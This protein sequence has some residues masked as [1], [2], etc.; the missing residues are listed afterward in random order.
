M[1]RTKYLEDKESI[2][3]TENTED[4]VRKVY[5]ELVY[6]VDSSFSVELDAIPVDCEGEKEFIEEV[7]GGTYDHE[8]FIELEEEEVD[9]DPYSVDLEHDGHHVVSMYR[10][11]EYE[12][13][14]RKHEAIFE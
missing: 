12:N 8:S 3:T 4:K 11:T 10:V 1:A 13:N 9:T 6:S 14:R 7:R 5:Y 2:M